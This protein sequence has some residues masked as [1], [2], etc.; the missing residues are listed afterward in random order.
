MAIMRQII[1]AQHLIS[2]HHFNLNILYSR[3]S[4]TF[5]AVT[6]DGK[7]FVYDMHFDKYYPLCVQS[8]VSKR[9]AHLNHISFNPSHPIIIVG[10]SRGE[11]ISLKLSPNLRRQSK[12][13]KLATIAKDMRK[14]AMMEVKKLENLLAQVR[15]I[16]G[17]DQDLQ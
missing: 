9:I 15:D 2:D 1:S 11:I 3:F 7:V 10:D 5:A 13:V 17:Q 12:E 4:T 6:Q 16:P 8:V 14:A